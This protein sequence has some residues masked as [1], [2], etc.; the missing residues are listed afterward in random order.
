[1]IPFY[2]MFLVLNKVSTGE[3]KFYGDAVVFKADTADLGLVEFYYSIPYDELVYQSK[4]DS[5]LAEYRTE[6]KVRNLN[7]PDSF[8]DVKNNLFYIKSFS[9]AREREFN[10]MDRYSL[11]LP[12]AE[13]EYTFAVSCS[14]KRAA[15][16]DR[17][18]VEPL[19]GNLGLSGILLAL[20]VAADTTPGKLNKNGLLIIPNPSGVYNFRY[21]TLYGYM[22][23]YGSSR[24]E[25]VYKIAYRIVNH[26]GD[27]VKTIRMRKSRISSNQTDV[28]VTSIAG[29]SGGEYKLVVEV[30]DSVNGLHAIQTKSFAVVKRPTIAWTDTSAE[31][32]KFY[33]QI[34]YLVSEKEYKKFLKYSKEGQAAYLKAFWQRNDYSEFEKRFEY[35]NEY[36]SVSNRKGADTDRGRIY[37]KYGPPDEKSGHSFE[38]GYKPNE[39]WT[40][41]AG[42]RFIFV[43]MK[44]SGDFMLV[45]SN[46][47]KE[48]TDPN[49]QKYVNPEEVERGD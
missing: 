5:I 16:S 29:L 19:T 26:V 7:L 14:T 41:Y 22:E 39:F 27:T 9:F 34:K 10:S 45:F 40:Y 31:K 49:W 2:L 46:T 36:F 32:G 35:V 18:K 12:L 43:D 11:F 20:N 15:V 28:V 44:G 30:A 38:T 42:L 4:G 17:I 3:I 47:E 8:V 6:F 33:D 48:R 24:G 25:T 13:Y 23:I 37:L 1:M 21:P